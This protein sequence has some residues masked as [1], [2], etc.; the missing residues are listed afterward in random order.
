MF[1]FYRNQQVFSVKVDTPNL[2][3]RMLSSLCYLHENDKKNMQSCHWELFSSD[4]D[5]GFYEIFFAWDE[6]VDSVSSRHQENLVHLPSQVT[7]SGSQLVPMHKSYV[8]WGI[9]ES[10]ICPTAPKFSLPRDGPLSMTFHANKM[11]WLFFF[12]KETLSAFPFQVDSKHLTTE[13]SPTET[14]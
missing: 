13:N 2:C 10:H 3:Q 12:F 8:K 9:R 7:I 4:R 5:K 6:I 11:H 1:N 14:A